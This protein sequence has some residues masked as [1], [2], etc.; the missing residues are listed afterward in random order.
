MKLR[1]CDL[2]QQIG[3]SPARQNFNSGV[4]DKKL[5]SAYKSIIN[6]LMPYYTDIDQILVKY[7]I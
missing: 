1:F 5:K 6:C 2:K 7:K 3:W 4:I